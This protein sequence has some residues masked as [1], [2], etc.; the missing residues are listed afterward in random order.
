[1]KG[2]PYREES[3]IFDQVDELRRQNLDRIEELQVLSRDVDS[4]QKFALIAVSLLAGAIFFVAVEAKIE[5]DTLKRHVSA[6]ECNIEAIEDFYNE[7]AEDIAYTKDLIYG[8][9]FMHDA[10][11][12]MRA[13]TITSHR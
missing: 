12:K 4:L 6:T 3:G 8:G 11:R 1:M 7:K 13:G 9:S 5:V 10:D 2:R